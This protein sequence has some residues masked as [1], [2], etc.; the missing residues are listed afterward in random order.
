VRKLQHPQEKN[1]LK[2]IPDEK[3]DHNY[4][5]FRN[6]EAAREKTKGMS[7]KLVKIIDRL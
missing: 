7:S 5:E 4:D 2:Q 3:L 6:T 1:K